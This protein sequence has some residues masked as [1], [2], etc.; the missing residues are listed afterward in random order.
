MMT[1]MNKFEDLYGRFASLGTGMTQSDKFENR[2]CTVL[3]VYY[4]WLYE[5][6]T[7]VLH[8]YRMGAS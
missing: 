1:L 3:F 7:Y 8:L 4:C 5:R 6:D 2:Q